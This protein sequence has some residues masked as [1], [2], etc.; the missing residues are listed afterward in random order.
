MAYLRT[1]LHDARAAINP[2]MEPYDTLLGFSLLM[3]MNK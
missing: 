2:H 3:C 1:R